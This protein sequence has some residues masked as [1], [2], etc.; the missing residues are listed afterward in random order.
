[1]T[2]IA[3]RAFYDCD[4]LR[5][6]SYPVGWITAPKSYFNFSD[7]YESPF[8]ECSL[9]TSVTIPEGIT[10]IPTNAFRGCSSL[11]ELVLP[12]TLTTINES[13]FLGCSGV[14]TLHLNDGLTT[15]GPFAF[16]NC[17]SIERV[18]FPA[19]VTSIASRAFYDCDDLREISYPV[20]WT[21]VPKSYSNFSD[22]YD[23]PFLGCEKLT[24]VEIPE[25]V[26]KIPAYA[27]RSCPAL[28]RVDFSES[29]T[30]I[31]AYAFSDCDAMT[32][33]TIPGTVKTIYHHAYSDCAQL[34]TLTL[35]N[36][37]KHIGYSAFSGTAIEEVTIPKSVAVLA[38]EK[39]DTDNDGWFYYRT[40]ASASAFYN[41][42][43]KKVVIQEGNKLAL[44]DY[45]FRN[46]T[47][48]QTVV[49]P[50]SVT[51]IGAYTFSG[52]TALETIDI[53]ASVRFIGANAFSG[54]TKL[55][56]VNLAAGEQV[57]AYQIEAEN[58]HI[59]QGTK[60]SNSN[61]SGGKVVNKANDIDFSLNVTKEGDFLFEEAAFYNNRKFRVYLDGTLYKETKG[62]GENVKRHAV[63]TLHLAEGMHTLRLTQMEGDPPVYDYFLIIP[64]NG[65]EV[66]IENSSV[67]SC[68][69]GLNYVDSN[70]VNG[71]SSLRNIY[72]SGSEEQ[73]GRI[74]Y[75]A[76]GN[77][78]IADA[79]ITFEHT[80]QFGDWI[81][82]TPATC[83][84][85][86]K[87]YRAC[88]TCSYQ[89]KETLEKTPHSYEAVE[90]IAP[91]Y[92]ENG[93]TVFKC[94]MCGEEKVD[95]YVDPKTRI[96]LSECEL[97]LEY[98]HAYYTGL[99]MTPGVSL[100]YLGDEYDPSVE[101]KLTYQE[102]DKAGIAMVIAEGVNRFKGTVEL[103]FELEY[104]KIP[105]QI[106]NVMAVGEIG[107][108]SL[109]WAISS[110]VNTDTYRIY[111][112]EGE[113]DFTLLKTINGRSTLSYSDTAVENDILYTY[114]VTGVGPIGEES[115]ASAFVS[116][117]TS[118]DMQ[119]PIVQKLTPADKS[120]LNAKVTLSATAVDNEKVVK[121][122]YSYSADGGV[123]W[124]PIGE[125]TNNKLSI[126]FDTTALQEE[127]I[128]V[129]VVAV[130]TAGNESEPYI[131]SYTT[132]N[133]GPEQVTGLIA[134]ALSSQITL[135]WS[136]VSAKDA[137][138]F[139]LQTEGEDGW[140]NVAT[141]ITKLGYV[142][143]GLQPNTTY[144]YR[145]CCVDK[146]GNV[147]AYS[148]TL[149]VRTLGDTAPPVITS[150]SPKSARYADTVPFSVTAKDDC[151][152]A[153]MQIQWS[154]DLETWTELA[155]ESYELGA[156]SKTFTFQVDLAAF[157]EG[158]LFLRG[159]ATDFSGNVSDTS[160]E[161]PVSEYIVDRTPPAAPQ[162]LIA[163]GKETYVRLTWEQGAE[164]DINKY[165]VY[166]SNSLNGNYQLVA[167]NLSVLSFNDTAIQSDKEYFY[168]LKVSD[169]AGNL[170]DY[171]DTVS[172][173]RSPDAT[174]PSITGM[175]KSYDQKISAQ[176]HT[177]QISAA[178]NVNLSSVHVLY[179]IN[180]AAEETPLQSFENLNKKT[181]TI[182][183]ALPVETLADGDTV[184]VIAIAEDLM[185]LQSEPEEMTYTFDAVAPEVSDFEAQLNGREV[186][187]TWKDCSEADLSGFRVYCASG[188]E[189]F[190]LLGSRAAN[191][192]GTYTFQDQI[193]GDESKTLTYQLEALDRLGN[194]SRVTTTVQY[195]YVYENTPPEV[196]MDVPE[197]LIVDVEEVFDGSR[198]TDNRALASFHWDFGDGTTSD[199]V[200]PVKKYD[201]VGTYTISLT[202]TDNEGAFSTVE[203]VVEVHERE[204]LGVLQIKVVD[205]QNNVL[206][207][208]PVYLD[209][210]SEKQFVIYTGINGVATTQLP[211]GVHLIG[212][213]AEG[214]LPVKREVPVL[215][216]ATRTVTLSTVKQDIVTGEFEIT[217]MTF[218]EVVAAGIDVNDPAN[219]NIYRAKVRVFYSGKPV[220]IYYTR[221]DFKIIEF[222]CSDTNGELN[223][224]ENGS[225][226]RSWIPIYVPCH[227]T[228]IVAILDIPAEASYL[229]DFFDV[230]LHIINNASSD[231]SLLQNEVTLNVPQGM[232]LMDH[233]ADG[234]A[235][236]KTVRIPSIRGQE[237]AT[238]SWVLRGDEAGEYDLSADFIGTLSDF[239][240]V[241]TARFETEEPIKVYGLEGIKFRILSS[242][243]IHNNTM[244]VHLELEN[245]R[246]V[247]LMMPNLNFYEKVENVT[248]EIL[249]NNPAG[250]FVV[251][252]YL[253]NVYVQKDDGEK[254]YIP[255]QY[256]DSEEEEN[257]W[258]SKPI[259]SPVEVLAPGQ[260][261]VYEYA[262]YNAIEYDDPA[263]FYEA[264]LL[265]FQGLK[266]NIEIGSFTHERYSYRDYSKKMADIRN[267]DD[268][269]IKD[270]LTYILDDGNYYYIDE[271]GRSGDRKTMRQLYHFAN[272]VLNADLSGLTQKEQ[273][274]LAQAVILKI[275]S[276]TKIKELAD[277][278]LSAKIEKIVSEFIESTK[279][280]LIKNDES[281]GTVDWSHTFSEIAKDKMELIQKFHDEGE[282]EFHKELLKKIIGYAEGFV[283]D[284]T[285]G[286]L[287]KSLG[288]DKENIIVSTLADGTT[289]PASFLSALSSADREVFIFACLRNDTN[290]EY[291]SLILDSI[292]DYVGGEL[293]MSALGRLGIQLD[294]FA[295]GD[296]PNAQQAVQWVASELKDQL[297]SKRSDEQ[298]RLRS[299]AMNFV[300]GISEGVA[301]TGIK[302]FIKNAFEKD[303]TSYISPLKIATTV[304]N[305][306]DAVFHFED[307]FM[308]EDTLEI[309]STISCALSRAFLAYALPENQ[310]SD[311]H[312]MAMLKSLCELRLDG[313]RQYKS[314]IDDFKDGKLLRLRPVEEGTVMALVNGVKGTDYETVRSWYEDLVFPIVTARDRLFNIELTSYNIPSA[315][316]VTLN[317]ETL[318]TNQTF[319]E[320]YEY[321][322]ADGVWQ[323]CSNA[324][325]PFEVRSVPGTLR[326]REAAA[327]DHLA[328]Q[329]TTVKIFAQKTLSKLISVRFDGCCYSFSHLSEKYNYQV[330]FTDDADAQ[331]DWSRAKTVRGSVEPVN[332]YGV[333]AY[334]YT[335]I[336]RM[337][338][339]E[340]QE[341]ASVPLL[342][343]IQK[344]LP[345]QLVI[346]GKGLVE[347]SAE[348][349]CY[350]AGDEIELHAIANENEAFV[351]WYIDGICVSS[352]PFYIAE[353][354]DDLCVKAA[355][356]GNVTISGIELLR[357]P[358][359]T[360]YLENEPLDLTGLK[361][362]VKYSD[363]SS[364]TTHRCTALLDSNLVGNHT[365]TV[366][367]GQHKA[368]FQI[369]VFHNLTGWQTICAATCVETGEDARACLVCGMTELQTIPALGHID[370]N[371]DGVCDRCNEVLAHR[372]TPGEVVIEHEIKAS[373]TVGGSYDEVV[374]CS[375]CKEELNR[376][377]KTTNPLQHDW[378][379]W[380]AVAESENHTRF[381]RRDNCGTVETFAHEWNDGE[382]TTPATCKDEGET[383]FT[384]AV[385]HATK[386]ASVD[387]LTTHTPGEAVKE[388]EVPS[389]STTPG[390]YDLVVYCSVCGE[391]LSREHKT[392]PVANH[393][394]Q[395]KDE[396]TK[397]PTCTEEGIMTFT[398][399][400]CGESYMETLPLIDHV[401]ENNDG[402]C[403]ACGVKLVGDNRCKYCGQIHTGFG[404]FFVKIFHSIAYSFSNLF[405]RKDTHT[406]TYRRAVTEP[407]CTKG[408]Y[409]TYTC[410]VCGESYTDNATEALGHNFGEWAVGKEAT[411][412]EEGYRTRVCARCGTEDKEA[413]P[414][415][416]HV[417][418]DEDGVCDVCGKKIE[419][420]EPTDPT[421]VEPE[422]VNENLCPY[423]GEEHTGFFGGITRG[424]HN[425]LFNL[426]GSK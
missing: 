378:S 208:A 6:I 23:S 319:N 242:D 374:Y 366:V 411:C 69:L 373:C 243:E 102:N 376:E 418:E 213:Y 176:Q 409:T 392:T 114:Y 181:V 343:T 84:S 280:G 339:E 155:S 133:V 246:D 141:K 398:C 408:G 116:A 424:F 61:A 224:L 372:H 14:Q 207:G 300:S 266:E 11:T 340:L 146:F 76:T 344:R 226:R 351:G 416:E 187:L 34:K 313:E 290:Y 22:H 282:E 194:T 119:P 85:T 197:H 42:K 8:Y 426:F 89:I 297:E 129:R 234:Y 322:F 336:R 35:E 106:V 139:T 379:N 375:V 252:A 48:L 397:K 413:L 318:E 284:G 188:D 77:G 330:F 321:C 175:S 291:C 380:T 121:A 127:A 99:P 150:Q 412:A 193:S 130:D 200:S 25:G 405:G 342:R 90:V 12:S 173:T 132:D 74:G 328:G 256:Q 254:Q 51:E 421:D 286:D 417:D 399:T 66:E 317:Y 381:C 52:C 299:F 20:G 122:V 312:A 287:Y 247:D 94:S 298:I 202:V 349:G 87:A 220:D 189:D 402:L 162:G 275:L 63:S 210:G 39:F 168:K 218:D 54:C 403:D 223:H 311:F 55:N 136:D 425:L 110:E 154:A 270:A 283:Y 108:I 13:A 346:E 292:L 406:H 36:G 237:T 182:S 422:P 125:T 306:V 96:E 326:V 167:E 401:D 231:F 341:T 103:H 288:I 50:D 15:I 58:A 404:G 420:D 79:T 153:K 303:P 211:A 389:N 273:R 233:L 423:C 382:I 88:A 221:N 156:A 281:T 109:S 97:S 29:V 407:T 126:E 64:R 3:S 73:F 253:L 2:S 86:G 386:T 271:A 163:L 352:D 7:H 142:V 229:K 279:K 170:S 134:T 195:T 230:K 240:E 337:P 360:E 305:I 350:F 18:D 255:I 95:E 308:Q 152:I 259:V 10:A 236:S 38:F 198:S 165:F 169:T 43:L 16:Q 333:A 277:D 157:D 274:S 358:D 215:A 324:P 285:Y 179:R 33:V 359:K 138:S 394:H 131:N 238:L 37:V 250:N 364:V 258:G 268:Q 289:V 118:L 414:T 105:A 26:T 124:L 309:Y 323:P 248:E 201:E 368:S 60:T 216:N 91:T 28:S 415:L 164:E 148:E 263:Y 158:S 4:A 145:V 371:Q 117:K 17:D 212:M 41:S 19:S 269:E 45:A 151:A 244:Y 72:Y 217:R 190:T 304:F 393:D 111:R 192:T 278:L 159:I 272:L 140:I 222:K 1:M 370:E 251:D 385:C 191:K 104:E 147:G 100:R 171:S 21:T 334:D 183:V 361:I 75:T 24:A 387:K 161:A 388:N 47:S 228:E 295:S 186:T 166:K 204:T 354:T 83:T 174:P 9:L 205:D 144:A 225:S 82:E 180:G 395:F 56:T 199:E 357:E 410:T 107:K 101:L 293:D 68:D 369:T 143:T 172:S 49:T 332:V 331:P 377:V 5:E 31:G 93:Y 315:P 355:F 98:T 294:Q 115:E 396:V 239:N 46:C 209:L 302:S 348:D 137:A 320:R 419:P 67:I 32:S 301:K 178:D 325:I 265:E 206:P 245:E 310:M 185:H 40:D 149:S 135:Q 112:K 80:H 345:L 214:Y 113:G 71:C 261:L 227:G 390:S 249:H 267:A 81:I 53:P 400:L 362:Q 257:G 59:T 196:V 70:A 353:M 365:V 177:I 219:Q 232:T 260:K 316:A 123:T 307:Y 356:E 241:V 57:S 27:F 78:A 264:M 338:N 92:T 347:Q 262:F 203:K 314:F 128:Q 367:V 384:C 327:D 120:V 160:A 44:R 363:G 62:D 235:T 335:I 296:F 65:G 30:T 184:Q 276:N 383:T 391:E 329:I